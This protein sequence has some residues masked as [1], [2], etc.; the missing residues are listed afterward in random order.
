MTLDVEKARE[1]HENEYYRTPHGQIDGTEL[2]KFVETEKGIRQYNRNEGISQINEE[3]LRKVATD[4]FLHLKLHMD[5]QKH[6]SHNIN[7]FGFTNMLPREALRVEEDGVY[8]YILEIGAGYTAYISQ[9]GSRVLAESYVA[10]SGN[11]VVIIHKEDA[12]ILYVN[13]RRHGI[14]QLAMLFKAMEP[15][16]VLMYDSLRS[17]AKWH[18]A[19]LASPLEDEEDAN[20]EDD[21]TDPLDALGEEIEESLSLR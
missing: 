9:D 10:C 6:G 8:Q 21:D 7:G 18:E 4:L 17:D 16:E 12:S 13:S 11:A 3:W 20:K 14:P 2:G 5:F 1:E 19:G 15:N